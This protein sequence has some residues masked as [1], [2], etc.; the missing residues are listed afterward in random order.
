[1]ST[2]EFSQSQQ[3]CK[4]TLA[5]WYEV[6]LSPREHHDHHLN[7]GNNMQAKKCGTDDDQDKDIIY[8]YT[9]IQ[10]IYLFDLIIQ[11]SLFNVSIL[12][13]KTTMLC[14]YDFQ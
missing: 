2:H 3:H 5:R 14:F 11:V 13:T 7:T 1:M 10:F 4:P 8:T 9:Y 6:L 12:Q